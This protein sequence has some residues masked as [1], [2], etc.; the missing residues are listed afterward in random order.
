MDFGKSESDS[1]EIP[2]VGAFGGCILVD[3]AGNILYNY[4]CTDNSNWPDV[5]VLLEQV[6]IHKKVID[7]KAPPTSKSRSASIAKGDTILSDSTKITDD[8]NVAVS[9]KK[10]CTIL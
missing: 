6:K 3:R 9:K 2:G 5:E 4:T 7:E 10:C 8:M 1:A